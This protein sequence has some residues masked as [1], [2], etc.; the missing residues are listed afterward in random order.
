MLPVPG[1]WFQLE[2]AN[3]AAANEDIDVLTEISFWTKADYQTFQQLCSDPKN[4][5]I[6]T[7]DEKQ[8]FNRN[9]MMMF[10]VE[11]HTSRLPVAA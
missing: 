9:V 5:S 7:E 6:L 2:A 8:L 1:S 10:L 4:A 3:D 11:P